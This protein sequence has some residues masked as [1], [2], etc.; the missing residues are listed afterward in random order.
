MRFSASH[1]R[2]TQH[3]RG[4]HSSLARRTTALGLLIAYL[5]ITTGVMVPVSPQ[6]DAPSAK[7]TERFPCEDRACGCAGGEQCWTHC[8]C[9]SLTQKLAW[10]KREGVRPPALALKLAL[11]QGADVS[12]WTDNATPRPRNTQKAQLAHQTKPPPKPTCSCCAA[13]HQ[14]RKS[15]Q[16]AKSQNRVKQ[17]SKKA[18]SETQADDGRMVILS[19]AL[20]CKGIAYQWMSVGEVVP[21]QPS[22]FLFD[23]KRTHESTCILAVSSDSIYWDLDPPPPRRV[24]RSLYRLI[25][26]PACALPKKDARVGCRSC[27]YANPFGSWLDTG[28]SNAKSR[29]FPCPQGRS[30][31]RSSRR[32][33]QRGG[34][35]ARIICARLESACMPSRVRTTD[36]SLSRRTPEP[37]RPG[38]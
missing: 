29:P 26:C 1:L 21:P 20:A 7:P 28:C 30:C 3:L 18:D 14:A 32:A 16:Q 4:T 9:Q 11:G 37:I 27:N 33:A 6:T 23:L 35:R 2:P 5:T 34:C 31:R 24:R 38:R 19:Q 12:T 15:T 22:G 36:G 13:K 25:P 10:A 17:T 8:R